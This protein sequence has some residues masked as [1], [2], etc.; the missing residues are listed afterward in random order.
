MMNLNI[1]N[2]LL[3]IFTVDLA[4]PLINTGELNPLVFTQI[5]ALGLIER[6]SFLW[7]EKEKKTK[8]NRLLR[9][10]NK[11]IDHKQ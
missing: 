7:K 10:T 5:D 3:S 2:N 11:I 8:A 1:R 9:P 6:N 4:R